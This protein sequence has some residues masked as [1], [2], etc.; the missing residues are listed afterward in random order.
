[1]YYIVK[2]RKVV[3]LR[4]PIDHISWQINFVCLKV[5][6]FDTQLIQ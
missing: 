5:N 3:M 4:N 6:I 2:N 1:M